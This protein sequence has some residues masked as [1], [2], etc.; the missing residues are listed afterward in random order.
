MPPM[1]SMPKPNP[2]KNANLAI[3]KDVSKTFTFTTSEYLRYKSGE[4]ITQKSE[5]NLINSVIY[6]NL[7][8]VIIPEEITKNLVC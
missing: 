6:L 4:L 5:K 1:P 7:N 3:N 8:P 2:K